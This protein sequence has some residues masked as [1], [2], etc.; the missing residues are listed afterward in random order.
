M[1]T[2]FGGAG[3][4]AATGP[5]RSAIGNHQFFLLNAKCKADMRANLSEEQLCRPD[6]CWRATRVFCP[7]QLSGGRLFDLRENAILRKNPA[8]SRFSEAAW[9]VAYCGFFPHAQL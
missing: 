3:V 5:P 9:P 7:G 8:T 2:G 6:F 1:A 4:C